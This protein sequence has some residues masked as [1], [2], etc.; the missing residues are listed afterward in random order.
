MLKKIGIPALALLAALV[1]IS[2]APAQAGVHFGV[3]VYAAP[4]VYSYP[5]PYPAYSYPGYYNPYYYAPGYVYPGVGLGF[6]HTPYLLLYPFVTKHAQ[7]AEIPPYAPVRQ[8]RGRTVD[9]FQTLSFCL[10]GRPVPK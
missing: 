10:V 8:L 5:A 6:G 1:F 9:H 4:P 7:L 3:G 2:P